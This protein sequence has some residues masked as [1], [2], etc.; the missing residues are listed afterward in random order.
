MQKPVTLGL[1]HIHSTHNAQNAT[2]TNIRI[3]TMH[4][5]VSTTVQEG[6]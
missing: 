2:D 4:G 1:E 6:C 3:K 5:I